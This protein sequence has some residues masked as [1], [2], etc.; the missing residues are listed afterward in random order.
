MR[1]L[2]A[3]VPGAAYVAVQNAAHIANMQNETDYNSVLRNFLL[4]Q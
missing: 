4:R 1:G 2:A 3:K